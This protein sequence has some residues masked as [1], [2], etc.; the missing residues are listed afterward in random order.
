MKLNVGRWLIASIVV[1]I[2]FFALEYLF[3][4]V[5]LSSMYAMT[6]NLWRAPE[7]MSYWLMTLSL[8]ITALLFCYIYTKGYE[9]K[10]SGALEGLKYGFII[11][12]FVVLPMSIGTY[13]VMPIPRKLAFYW[14]IMGMFE[15]LLAGLF[16]GLIYKKAE[17]PAA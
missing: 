15:F 14:F 3:H 11:G 2:I 10:P 9:A 5:C 1:L 8:I 17:A 6:S 16:V 4:T 13:C 7:E 12:L